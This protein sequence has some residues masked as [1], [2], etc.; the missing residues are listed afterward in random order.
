MKKYKAGQPIW[1]IKITKNSIPKSYQK[2]GVNIEELKIIGVSKYKVVLN[3][4][5]FTTFDNDTI[6]GYR[7]DRSIYSY[8]DDIKVSIRTNNNI[9]GDGVF[10]TLYS[11]KK[12]TKRVLNKMYGAVV[13][14]IDNDYGFLFNGAKDEIYSLIENFEI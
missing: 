6:D 10:V 3:D 13:S 11:S 12:P 9:L 5:W 1:K 7:K 2:D 14:K 8:I 4:D